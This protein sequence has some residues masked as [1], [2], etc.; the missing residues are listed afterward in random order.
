MSASV[1]GLSQGTKQ[2]T[3]IAHCLKDKCETRS[4]I[5]WSTRWQR[6]RLR[7]WVLVK[8]PFLRQL[9]NSKWLRT[10]WSPSQR[11]SAVPL[12]KVFR[13]GAGLVFLSMFH[14]IARRNFAQ[15]FC[16]WSGKRGRRRRPRPQPRKRRDYRAR[17]QERRRAS[18]CKSSNNRRN[19][20]DRFAQGRLTKGN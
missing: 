14:Q 13:T 8:L 9:G 15:G 10:R 19:Q 18:L 17:L 12:Q 16:P 7:R 20:I 6:S 2:R 1:F 3:R 11:D 5:L 4:R